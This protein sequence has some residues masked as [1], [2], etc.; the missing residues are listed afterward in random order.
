M[1]DEDFR[2]LVLETES[3]SVLIDE[4][5]DEEGEELKDESNDDEVNFISTIFESLI[6]YTKHEGVFLLDELNLGS[7]IDFVQEITN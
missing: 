7:M 4:S 1:K 6:E 2:D 3:N 5:E